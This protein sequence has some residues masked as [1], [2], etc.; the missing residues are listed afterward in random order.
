MCRRPDRAFLSERRYRN[1]C[2]RTSE[3]RAASDLLVTCGD[4]VWHGLPPRRAD[5]KAARQGHFRIS[6]LGVGARAIAVSRRVR[7]RVMTYRSGS[8]DSAADVPRVASC[9]A[10]TSL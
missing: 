6:D 1:H 3:S 5:L 7:V 2:S 9:A 10:A 4:L 8:V